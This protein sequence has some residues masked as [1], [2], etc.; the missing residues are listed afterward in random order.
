MA[1]RKWNRT[2]VPVGIAKPLYRQS[3]STKS[4]EDELNSTSKAILRIR[5]WD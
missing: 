1:V 3:K 2:K 5:S 4:G